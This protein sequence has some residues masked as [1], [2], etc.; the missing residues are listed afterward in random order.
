M[1]MLPDVSTP[2]PVDPMRMLDAPVI[3]PVRVRLPVDTSAKRVR[4]APL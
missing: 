2:K 4:V 1:N 3:E